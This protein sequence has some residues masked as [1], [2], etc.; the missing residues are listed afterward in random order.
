MEQKITMTIQA[1]FYPAENDEF[2][3]L[4]STLSESEQIANARAMVEQTLSENSGD[5]LWFRVESEDNDPIVWQSTIRQSMVEN[6]SAEEVAEMI[7]DLDNQIVRGAE[8]YDLG[9]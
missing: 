4:N 3:T 9:D 6:L 1:E 7:D 5:G 8:N 2:Q